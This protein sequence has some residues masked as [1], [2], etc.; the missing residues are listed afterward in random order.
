MPG[1]RL[2]FF[3][4]IV[5][6][7]TTISLAQ[8]GT[9][10]ATFNPGTCANGL[11]RAMAIDES[12]RILIGGI[13]TSYNGTTVGRIARLN[14]DGTL[15]ASF[16]PGGSGFTNA[17]DS[18]LA[19]AIESS[20]NILVGGRFTAYN[21]IGP[22]P[23]YIMRLSIS[24]VDPGNFSP[25]VLNGSAAG[26]T[27]HVR[28]IAVQPDGNIIVAGDWN[29]AGG[30]G[31][32]SPTRRIMR[33][34]PTGS[35]DPAYNSADAAQG[36]TSGSW[37]NS[38]AIQQDGK[39]I[40]AGTFTSYN[41]LLAN[42]IVRVNSNGGR[43]GTF[44]CG[45]GAGTNGPINKMIVLPDGDILIAGNFNTIGSP[46]RSMIARLNA[47]GTVDGAFNAAVSAS[48]T[49]MCVQRDGKIVITGYF[50]TVNGVTR[51]RIARLNSDGTLDTSFD[52]G[53]GPGSTIRAAV[54][55]S[56]NQLLIGGSFTDYNG[57]A[58]NRI[59]RIK[60]TETSATQRNS[61]RFDGIDDFITI[62][63]HNDFN[64]STF[65]FEAWIKTPSVINPGDYAIFSKEGASTDF[66]ISMVSAG[67]GTYSAVRLSSD[68]F[69]NY[70]MKPAT[71][72]FA[73]GPDEW[74]HILV[75]VGGFFNARR[76]LVD[77]ALIYFNNSEPVGNANNTYPLKIGAGC[78]T[79]WPGQIDDV[80]FWST[81]L[82][83]NV[84]TRDWM[85]LE[86]TAR[87]T[88]YKHGDIYF[89]K[90]YWQFNHNEGPI[91]E[92]SSTWPLLY[93]VISGKSQFSYTFKHG[94]PSIGMA[95]GYIVPST[96]P[97]G[98][99]GTCNKIFV[100]AAGT[101]N[102]YSTDMSLAFS[103][104]T[105]PAE[106]IAV[107]HVEHIVPGT[108]PSNVQI[109]GML[110]KT[111]D[112]FWI[113][114]NFNNSNN[115]GLDVSM[116]LTGISGLVNG[117]PQ[118][119]VAKRA[120]NSDGNWIIGSNAATGINSATGQATFGGITSF[121][122]FV[123]ISLDLSP[124]P[125]ELIDFQATHQSSAILLKWQTAS[126]LNNDH[127]IIE[128]SSTGKEFLPIG[129][130]EGNGTTK[131]IHSYSFTDTKPFPGKNYYRLTQY[132][133]DGKKAYSPIRYLNI[134]SQDGPLNIEVYPNPAK[135]EITIRSSQ[136]LPNASVAFYDLMSGLIVWEK[137]FDL[138]AW[139]QS[140]DINSIKPGLYRVF[141]SSEAGKANEKVV[142][143]R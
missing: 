38:T 96:A 7:S 25:P 33:L 137:Q 104:T 54:H 141:V 29:C 107:T 68:V 53:S 86:L 85:H 5:I 32:T 115:S 62:N 70:E 47:D 98:S 111:A 50:T 37:V 1:L 4:L 92:E 140:V 95:S 77:N 65:T 69:G 27:T 79:Y 120:T 60:S 46:T 42:R 110:H 108:I 101:Y 6:G 75:V 20:G 91:L 17:A 43:D 84:Y 45:S 88:G 89:L 90:G 67:G 132:D 128:H 49:A 130:V 55:A 35:K 63:H 19:I 106:D 64:V 56:N 122:Q 118:L 9:I 87:G 58:R 31:C 48:I 112:E 16:N 40:I 82:P 8:E 30:G 99:M 123:P 127:F 80:R 125:V 83:G 61:V 109:P 15:D 139:E 119:Y 81:D 71:D 52:P 129:R 23:D 36:I 14:F 134:E 105:F 138:F 11:I 73:L 121:S 2:R 66:C 131:T 12:G 78:N 18:V 76:L 74:H 21:G 100:N 51:N 24:G 97:L 59:A 102:F 10:D 3:F 39:I 116:T 72:P 126:E 57:T 28:A 103:G 124:L 34:L 143:V 26:S 13:F 93:E 142:V 94:T 114:R 41:S 22:S 44:L 113:V 135:D 136:F 117:D 133:L